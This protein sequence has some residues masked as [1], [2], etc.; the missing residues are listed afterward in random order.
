[1]NGA[2]DAEHQGIN[3]PDEKFRMAYSYDGVHW[4][5]LNNNYPVVYPTKGDTK[6]VRDPFIMRN[7][8]GSFSVLATQGWD[9]PYIYVWQSENLTE[10]TNE[11]LLRASQSGVAGLTGSRAWAPEG[12][13]DPI[14]DQYY[15]YW[16]DPSASGEN[17]PGPIYYNTSKDLESLS[18]PG[19][20][21]DPGYNVIDS[22]IVKHDG[23]YYMAFKDERESGKAIKFAKSTSLAPG[24]FEIYT[25][26]FVTDKYAE[27]PFVFKANGENKW[28][29]YWDFFYASG[30]RFGYSVTDDLGKECYYFPLFDDIENF[31][32]ENCSDGD[33]LITMGAG[34]VVKIGESLLGK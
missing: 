25:D 11:R 2:V 34:D 26:E 17:G 23:V 21:F 10:F 20:Y 28:F 31:I 16:A 14:T 12:S 13:Y 8:D 30:D 7:K 33:L 1:A 9:T 3:N 32:L 29:H 18:T 24:S 15:L 19:L 27:G 22:N 4:E 6:R 5:K